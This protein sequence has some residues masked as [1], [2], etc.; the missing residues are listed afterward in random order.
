MKARV[1]GTACTVL[2]ISILLLVSGCAQTDWV[3][4]GNELYAQRRYEDAISMYEKAIA[5][6]PSNSKAL[7]GKGDA[8]FYL[9]A[10]EDAVASYRKADWY[11]A[12]KHPLMLEAVNRA[13]AEKPDNSDMWS[14]KGDILRE[15]GP[16]RAAIECY[17]KAIALNPNNEN[18][19]IGKYNSYIEGGMYKEA[20]E[21]RQAGMNAD[22][23]TP[24]TTP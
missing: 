14:F 9:K 7:I 6:N 22:S 23:Y 11:E 1:F 16:Q 2:V 18:A 10:Y 5:N 8:L 24:V 12:T 13:L 20:E 3:K 17:D 21:L 4:K 19:K 15:K